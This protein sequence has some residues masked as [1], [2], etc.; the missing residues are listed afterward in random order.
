MKLVFIHG[1]NQQKF[2]ANSFQ[3]HWYNVFN[4]GL[5]SN[6]LKAEHVD[7][8]F[9]FY[10]DILS[11]FTHKNHKR[12]QQHIAIPILPHYVK[13]KRSLIQNIILASQFAK[14]HA[15]KEM[16]LLLNHFPNF[17][18]SLIQR[19]LSEAYL[20][21]YDP[22]F[23]D[24]VHQRILSFFGENEEHIVISHSLGTVV[25]Y[26]VL[27]KLP[28]HIKVSRFIT[29]AS[30]MPFNV[31]QKHLNH[32]IKRPH[33][34]VGDWINFYSKEDYLTTYKM[35]PPL[36]NLDPPIINREIQTFLDR[37]HEIMGY[38]QHPSVIRCILEKTSIST[39]KI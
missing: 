6:Q 2:D 20:Y 37:P 31:I 7:L 11:K 26:N 39:E 18:E 36:F 3:Q 38:L 22:E 34:L 17:H 28:E 16:V 10:G 24:Q 23:K 27:Q 21:W 35:S 13:Q 12:L 19:F 29:L 5:T 9:A 4:L 14:D 1:I 30:P 25:A 33:A 8:A 15:L 32:P